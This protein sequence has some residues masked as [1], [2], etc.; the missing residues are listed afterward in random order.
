M[1]ANKLA[2][3][4]ACQWTEIGFAMKFAN[5]H[6]ALRTRIESLID[7]YFDIIDEIATELELDN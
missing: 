3:K 5:G 4:T 2:D 6:S 7:S 1:A